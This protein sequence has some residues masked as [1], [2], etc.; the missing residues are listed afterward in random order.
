MASSWRP[1]ALSLSIFFFVASSTTITLCSSI[2]DPND[3]DEIYDILNVQPP[4]PCLFPG[5][6]RLSWKLHSRLLPLLHFG[7]G[8]DCPPDV[9][10][11]LRVLWNKALSS[12]DTRSSANE[13][14]FGYPTFHQLPVLSRWILLKLIPVRL[15]PRWMHAN[16]ELRTVFLNKAVDKEISEVLGKGQVAGIEL[17][18]LGGGYDTRGTRMLM[19]Y[20]DVELSLIHI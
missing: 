14:T 2:S 6:K 4:S 16:I 10:V 7:Q 13:K 1:S 15:Y 19:Q 17:V 20:T 3:H 11:N 8:E 18:I 5:L 9:F 12:L